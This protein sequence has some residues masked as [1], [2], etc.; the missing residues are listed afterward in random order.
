[1]FLNMLEVSTCSEEIFWASYV[2][3]KL[4]SP[5]GFEFPK[6]GPN[7][8]FGAMPRGLNPIA[9]G[10]HFTKKCGQRRKNEH[11]E[12]FY[13]TGSFAVQNFTEAYVDNSTFCLENSDQNS[14]S[15]ENSL[16]RSRNEIKNV[17]L[18]DSFSKIPSGIKTPSPPQDNFPPVIPSWIISPIPMGTSSKIPSGDF[19]PITPGNLS[20]IP[21]DT[22]DATFKKSTSSAHTDY[23]IHLVDPGP[24]TTAK[25]NSNSTSN[26]IPHIK[27]R[28]YNIRQ[29]ILSCIFNDKKDHKWQN[30]RIIY[31][32][33]VL[34]DYNRLS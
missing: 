10:D 23:K 1:M 21:E 16:I 15:E 26:P 11:Y 29:Q 8:G 7:P 24:K 13:L 31:E 33:R 3:L 19:F 18:E 2:P 9:R 4:S 32:T 20:K 17:L 22:I 5:T 6:N 30:T 25:P 27:L 28:N 14:K 34:H 12:L